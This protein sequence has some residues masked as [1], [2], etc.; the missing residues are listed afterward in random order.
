MAAHPLLSLARG[1][2]VHVCSHVTLPLCSLHPSIQQKNSAQNARRSLDG[3]RGV[4]DV[5]WQRRSGI[6]AAPLLPAPCSHP[7]PRCPGVLTRMTVCC[8]LVAHGLAGGC[9][10]AH[11]QTVPGVSR[12]SWDCPWEHF[13]SSW[14]GWLSSC[15]APAWHWER[16]GCVSF[17]CLR[18]LSPPACLP[19]LARG[20][21]TGPGRRRELC[22]AR[23]W[24]WVR[25]GVVLEQ[26]PE[27]GP[28]S[29]T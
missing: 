23:S 14:R 11:I 4:L 13:V 1:V 24:H 22:G 8:S 6:L 27:L 26:C 16:G 29:S 5:G 25:G 17:K 20:A 12:M 9:H 7:V 21:G 18:K 3:W 19:S 15:L 2:R 10:R 28:R